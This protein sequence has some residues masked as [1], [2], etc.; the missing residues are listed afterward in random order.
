MSIGA[1][2]LRRVA[3]CFATGVVVVTY[4]LGEETHGIT[5]NSF[6]SLSLDPPLVL[7]CVDR[8]ARSYEMLPLAG[9]FGVNVLNQEQREISDYFARRLYP[10]PN[11]ELRDLPYH[12][13]ITGSP[14]IDGSV[15]HLECRIVEILGG[16]DHAIFIGEVL[17][18]SIESDQPPLLFH[19]GRYSRICD[20]VAAS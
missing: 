8:K 12:L 3:G 19:R 20:P 9:T 2:E 15:A 13:G 6:T 17:A 1:M 18:A 14:L 4:R 16:G 5:V 10:D 11:D 7:V